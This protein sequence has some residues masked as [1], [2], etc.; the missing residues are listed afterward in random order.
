MTTNIKSLDD[1]T[2]INQFEMKTLNPTHFDHKGH[3]R[4]AWLYLNNHE[5]EKA[6]DLTC[7]GIKAYAESLGAKGKFHLTI[8]DALVRIM[9][10]RIQKNPA[11]NW[12]YFLL[13]NQDLVLNSLEVIK[14]FYSNEVLFSNE[15][16][17]SLV[18][19]DIK[20]IV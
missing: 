19:P 4:L 11:N 3:I 1:I 13:V 8:T 18:K 9:A 5:L 14:Q 10:Q 12:E 15:A 6:I 20:Q 2:F 17:C 16:K 7:N